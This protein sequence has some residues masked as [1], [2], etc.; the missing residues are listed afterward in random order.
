MVF[1]FTGADCIRSEPVLKQSGCNDYSTTLIGSLW[2]KPL[3]ATRSVF[4]F[5]GFKFCSLKYLPL[6]EC[7]SLHGTTQ[8]SLRQERSYLHWHFHL[9]VPETSV[10][11]PRSVW[12]QYEHIAQC[13]LPPPTPTAEKETQLCVHLQP[14]IFSLFE[15]D[16]FTGNSSPKRQSDL[17][18]KS[19]MIM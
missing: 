4:A 5:E 11:G 17:M 3:S 16:D 9:T 13:Q 14:H 12:L 10:H 7:S 8:L 6:Q 19:D 2:N 1:P 15:M 18:C